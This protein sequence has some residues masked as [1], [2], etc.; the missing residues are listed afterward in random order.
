MNCQGRLCSPYKALVN[1]IDSEQPTVY[2]YL[3]F[4]IH[5]KIYKYVAIEK[6]QITET[7][8]TDISQ[9]VQFYS[10]LINLLFDVLFIFIYYSLLPI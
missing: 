5:C 3:P 6:N 2:N 4:F 7:E 1:I 10:N 8:K 9:N